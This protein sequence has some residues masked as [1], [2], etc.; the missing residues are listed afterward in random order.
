LQFNGVVS[1]LPF[2]FLEEIPDG[3]SFNRSAGIFK[4]GGR[5]PHKK[6]GIHCPHDCG[7]IYGGA[8]QKS[9]PWV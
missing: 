1:I 2:N 4:A 5:F 6:P 7:R 3:E 8:A 9:F